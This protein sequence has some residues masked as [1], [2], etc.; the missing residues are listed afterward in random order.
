MG[1]GRRYIL[2]TVLARPSAGQSARSPASIAG[3][4]AGIVPLH[5]MRR[6]TGHLYF[7]VLLAILIGGTIGYANPA[8]GIALKPLGDGFIALVKML[9]SPIIFCTVVLGIA[10]AG[11]MKKVGRVGGKTLLYF[12]AVSTLALIIGLIVVNVMTIS[13]I[14]GLPSQ[15]Q[16]RSQT[17]RRPGRF[18]RQTTRGTF[19]AW[20]CICVSADQACSSA[21]VIARGTSG[22]AHHER[23]DFQSSSPDAGSSYGSNGRG[24]AREALGASTAHALG[25]HH[26]RHCRS[27]HRDRRRRADVAGIVAAPF[28][29]DH[30][31]GH[32][33]TRN[34][35]AADA[36]MTVGLVSALVM[37]WSR[38]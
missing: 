7:W 17:Q 34:L 18:S 25:T 19:R 3:G 35:D 6:L 13:D 26:R 30:R 23:A 32:R 33:R 10:G 29:P 11:D 16:A 15:H 2:V 36:G 31:R 4:S 24:G 12:E 9:I 20:R 8:A 28:R 38:A 22:L 37:Q 5:R 1:L 27:A 21:R 14:S